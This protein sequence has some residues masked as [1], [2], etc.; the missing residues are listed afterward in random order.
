MNH[1][2]VSN[3]EALSLA[4]SR[5]LSLRSL[6]L[7]KGRRRCPEP[8]EEVGEGLCKGVERVPKYGHFDK[9]SDHVLVGSRSALTSF[10]VA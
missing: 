3:T 2:A 7:S 1:I 10:L 8:A 9:L 4:R 6:S 5:S